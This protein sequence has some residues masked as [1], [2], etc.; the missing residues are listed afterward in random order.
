MIRGNVLDF[1]A[2]PQKGREILVSRHFHNVWIFQEYLKTIAFKFHYHTSNLFQC[3]LGFTMLLTHL[4][5]INLKTL[6]QKYLKPIALG[7]HYHMNNVLQYSLSLIK[8]KKLNLK[9]QRVFIRITSIG[10]RLVRS[11]RGTHNTE[12]G[13]VS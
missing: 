13:R 3:S 9:L 10:R 11:R 1:A 5:L 8:V 6:S 4:S 12:I 2:F 7:F